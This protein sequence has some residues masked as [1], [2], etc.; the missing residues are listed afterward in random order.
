MMALMWHLL[1]APEFGTPYS[2]I[3]KIH[4]FIEKN[5]FL[6]TALVGFVKDVG[7]Y[8]IVEIGF[9]LFL[10]IL[11]LCISIDEIKQVAQNDAEIFGSLLRCQL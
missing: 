4:I 2:K 3:V 6:K 10:K 7:F 1:M 8:N 11:V 5:G 9:F